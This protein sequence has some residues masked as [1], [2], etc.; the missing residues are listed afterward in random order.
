MLIYQSIASMKFAVF[1]LAV[2]GCTSAQFTAAGQA[3]IVKAHNDLRSSIAKGNYVAAGRKMPS[4]ANMLKMKFDPEL[5]ASAQKYA[6]TCPTGH[7]K[8]PGIG[9]NMYWE[10]F[11]EPFPENLDYLGLKACQWWEKEF[12]DFGWQSIEMS[13]ELF[14]TGIGHAT[15]MAW[16]ETNSVGCGV[17]RCGRDP[18]QKNMYKVMI[19][20][21]YKPPGNYFT[22]PI[23]KPGNACTS[24]F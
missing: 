7:S 8:W 22:R 5:A 24:E 6:D 20:C 15:Q 2:I 18:S 17:K 14:N 11:S 23:Y 12:Q 21:Q 3:A 1:I 9:E 13:Q 4:A 19:I 10:W 16:A